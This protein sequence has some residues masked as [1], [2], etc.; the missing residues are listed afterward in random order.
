MQELLYQSA[1]LSMTVMGGS[2]RTLTKNI[3]YGGMSIEIHN[4]NNPHGINNIIGTNKIV[5]V[6][7]D[8]EKCSAS[9]QAQVVRRTNNTA[10]LMFIS[11]TLALRHFVNRLSASIADSY[12]IA[13]NG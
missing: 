5:S 10:A 12:K 6:R 1:L 7:F 13:M 4:P 11:H 9:L 2:I 8:E 3:S